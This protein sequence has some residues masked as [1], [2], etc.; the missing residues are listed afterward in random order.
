MG[1]S[2][3]GLTPSTTYDALI[4]V[5]DNGPLSATAKVL[6]DGL[7]ND[8]ILA[9]STSAVG[10]GTNTPV[11][12]LHVETSKTGITAMSNV[13]S[14]FRSQAPGRDIG[15]QFSDGTNQAYIGAL[16]GAFYI[17]T[18]GAIERM[19]IT[20][21]GNVGIGT[22]NLGGKFQVKVATDA[23]IAFN[24]VGGVSRIS[25]FDDAIAV[26]K[27]LIIS[28]E[29]IRFTPGGTEIARFTSNGLTF[30]GD[31]A[32]ANA[33]DDYEEGTWTPGFTL[34]SGSVSA[35]TSSGSYTKIGRQ[36]SVTM[37][38]T[39]TT[40][41][42]ATINEITGLPFTAQNLPQNA[43]GAVRESANAG[44]LWQW[45]VNA[46]STQGLLRKYDNTQVLTNGDT[47]IGTLTYFV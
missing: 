8:S 20:S 43:V 4:K 36:V 46:N 40:T 25:C 10:I 28:G 2:L 11:V 12:E 37:T 34:D 27:P 39:F 1:T 3:T 18:G 24:E 45:R 19:C 32:A 15:I 7:G 44:T 47:F 26:S 17:G 41:L 35:F 14:T 13:I 6:S 38:I 29:S 16:S 21:A 30:N 42:L 9:L 31:T 33:L 22:S 5:G 23:N